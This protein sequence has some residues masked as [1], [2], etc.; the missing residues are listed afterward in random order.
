[1][2]Y[3]LLPN[4]TEQVS[5]LSPFYLFTALPF[6]HPDRYPSDF[7]GARTGH[8]LTQMLHSVQVSLSTVTTSLIMLMAI[9]GH[10]SMH[11]PH[12]VHLLVSIVTIVCS[13]TAIYCATDVSSLL[14]FPAHIRQRVY[15]LPALSL[16]SPQFSLLPFCGS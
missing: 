7:C 9:T 3:L 11:P 5:V 4:L 12:P 13:F 14:F 1:M 8:T 6:H 15:D 2:V 10:K 16:C